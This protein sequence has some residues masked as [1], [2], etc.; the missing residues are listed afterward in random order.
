MSIRIA[1]AAP[2]SGK[3]RILTPSV[4]GVS[5]GK[6]FIY[7]IPA[8]GAR[9]LNIAACD[10]PEG[11]VLSDNVLS[12]CIAEKGEWIIRIAAENGEGTAEKELRLSCAEDNMLLTPLLGFTTWNAFAHRVTQAD[13]ERTASQ[14]VDMGIADYGYGYVNLDSGWQKEYGGKFD[15]IIPNEKFPDMKAM[16]DHI[17]S[18]GLRGGIYLRIF[19]QGLFHPHDYRMGMSGRSAI[20]SRLHPRRARFPQHQRNGR[21]RQGT[22]GGKQC[23]SVGRMGR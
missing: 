5:I 9:P 2:F 23:P 14:L 11:V 21:H 10:L 20:H 1:K 19:P 22:H 13:M 15:A 18:L 17:H 6:P 8:I 16:Y 12:G 7:R 3:P 4:V